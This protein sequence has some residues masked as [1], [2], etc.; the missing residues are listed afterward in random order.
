MLRIIK[1]SILLLVC[2]FAVIG[3]AEENERD[4]QL[5]N[6]NIKEEL[7]NKVKFLSPS[8]TPS[9]SPL[10]SPVNTEQPDEIEYDQMVTYS[11]AISLSLVF[12][13]ICIGTITVSIV[14]W[15]LA[16]RRSEYQPLI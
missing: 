15:Q 11:L 6:Q 8:N 5:D 2:L 9:P 14:R 1:V 13:V 4:L 16:K 12:L 10:P 3:G 7:P